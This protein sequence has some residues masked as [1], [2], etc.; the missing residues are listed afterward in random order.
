MS[1]TKIC[2]QVLITAVSTIDKNDRLVQMADAPAVRFQEIQGISGDQFC[3]LFSR[4]KGPD[5]VST[6]IPRRC[7][8]VYKHFL[9]G[10]NEGGLSVCGQTEAGCC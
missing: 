9:K 7:S 3:L 1:H 5:A 10:E 4:A 6:I 2:T 8:R